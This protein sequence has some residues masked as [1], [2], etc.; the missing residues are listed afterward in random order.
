M[1]N[2][3]TSRGKDEDK[4][5]QL[6]S[7]LDLT[8]YDQFDRISDA[9]EKHATHVDMAMNELYRL[10]TDYDERSIADVESMLLNNV[11][12]LYEYANEL[13]K[14]GANYQEKRDGIAEYLYKDN[15]NRIEEL[16]RLLDCDKPFAETMPK[17]DI[18]QI[19]EEMKIECG[20][21]VPVMAARTYRGLTSYMFTKFCAEAFGIGT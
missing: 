8:S 16:S 14:V 21:D 17:A 19:M 15:A 18:I 5:D 10:T 1:N 3:E 4:F 7:S 13:G 20:G 2:F 6:I 12:Y 11:F 9:R